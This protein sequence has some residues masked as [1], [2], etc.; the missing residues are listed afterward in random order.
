MD[1]HIIYV[2]DIPACAPRSRQYFIGSVSFYAYWGL[3]A[4]LSGAGF[5]GFK[6]DYSVL[7]YYHMARGESAV[8]TPALAAFFNATR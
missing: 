1:R 2:H 5:A 6:A 4:E 3:C 8:P 7:F